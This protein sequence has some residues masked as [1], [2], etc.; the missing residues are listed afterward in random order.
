VLQVTPYRD[1]P[2]IEAPMWAERKGTDMQGNIEHFIERYIERCS[3]LDNIIQQ[4]INACLKGIDKKMKARTMPNE[5]WYRPVTNR[6]ETVAYIVGRGNWISSN[7]E[8]DMIPYG[9]K[10]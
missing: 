7:L 10:I 5:K 8:K 1:T 2:Y 3:H 4:R 9:V 6:K